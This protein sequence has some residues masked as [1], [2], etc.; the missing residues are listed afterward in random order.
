MKIH[1]AVEG[2]GVGGERG[3]RRQFLSTRRRGG[4]SGL[5]KERCSPLPSALKPCYFKEL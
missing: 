1:S 3:K 4:C 5:R 2:L